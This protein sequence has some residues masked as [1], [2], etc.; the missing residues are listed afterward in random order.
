MKK[1]FSFTLFSAFLFSTSLML[2]SC[3]GKPGTNNI[4][5]EINGYQKASVCSET[6]MSGLK[7]AVTDEAS[8]RKMLEE[9]SSEIKT[10][11]NVQ[12]TLGNRRANGNSRTAATNPADA[13]VQI[14]AYIKAVADSMRQFYTD[15]RNLTKDI[16]SYKELLDK[17]FEFKI[18]GSIDVEELT[19]DGWFEAFAGALADIDDELI[20][21]YAAMNDTDGTPENVTVGG[22]Q[23]NSSY[24]AKEYKEKI[25]AF[26]DSQVGVV[27]VDDDVTKTPAE[28]FAI[29]NKYITIKKFFIGTN[30]QT[31]VNIN[32]ILNGKDKEYLAAKVLFADLDYE[33]NF[34]VKDINALVKEVSG[35]E[36]NPNIPLKGFTLSSKASLDFDVSGQNAYD[37][38]RALAMPVLIVANGAPD[39][40][41]AKVA[42]AQDAVF[43]VCTESGLGGWFAVKVS[44]DI[45]KEDVKK[46]VKKIVAEQSTMKEGEDVQ[47][48][49]LT[50]DDITPALDKFVKVSVTV[51]DNT[52]VVWKNEW[53]LSEFIK[54]MDEFFSKEVIEA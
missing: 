20:T 9:V 29:C 5:P 50:L 39:V 37:W 10:F 36:E 11:N 22:I 54:L 26:I 25:L 8:F 31:N 16:K 12:E 27:T 1:N 48:S 44:C 53:A 47:Y 45:N 2:L 38:A 32:K 33:Y 52:K 35:M 24:T 6:E 23:L 7:V 13:S 15:I 30:I 14:S 18:N 51:A 3:G 4:N 40:A 19:I 28:L 17:T 42:V 46:I 41:E 49:A 43:A 21:F 34:V